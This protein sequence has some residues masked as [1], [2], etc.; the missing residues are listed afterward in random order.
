[1]FS[2]FMAVLFVL[3]KVFITSV[4]QQQQQK[5]RKRKFFSLEAFLHYTIIPPK[6]NAFNHFYV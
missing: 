2:V 6:K 1:M 3:F 4:Q 5:N